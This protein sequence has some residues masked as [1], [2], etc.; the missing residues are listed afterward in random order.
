[1]ADQADI[2]VLGLAVMGAN[3]ARNAAHKG[4]GVAVF[5]RNHERTDALIAEHGKEGRF[6]PAKELPEFIASIAKPRPILIMVKAGKPVDD[7]IDELLPQ[8]EEGDIIRHDTSTGPFSL[9]PLPSE[10][11][12]WNRACAGAA[13]VRPQLAF[14]TAWAAC[15]V[16]PNVNL[17]VFAIFANTLATFSLATSKLSSPP[18]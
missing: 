12:R 5:N 3:L 17:T 2:G 4:F 15:V 14:S 18:T 7:V 13:H 9:P 1:M 11:A 8:L 6:F 10:V 16:V